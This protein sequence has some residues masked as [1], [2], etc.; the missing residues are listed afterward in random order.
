MLTNAKRMTMDQGKRKTKIPGF[1]LKEST[2]TE[3]LTRITEITTKEIYL[4]SK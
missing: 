3:G 2:Q 4:I 1:K